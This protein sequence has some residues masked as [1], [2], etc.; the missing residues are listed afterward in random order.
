MV[1]PSSLCIVWTAHCLLAVAVL[2]VAALWRRNSSVLGILLVSFA[3]TNAAA[4]ASIGVSM[5]IMFRKF[6]FFIITSPP[7]TAS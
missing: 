7:L 3:V 2:H 1:A 5:S 4:I 6:P